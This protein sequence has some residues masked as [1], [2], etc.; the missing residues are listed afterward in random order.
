M[1]ATK[2]PHIIPQSYP[3]L[4]IAEGKNLDRQTLVNISNNH[5]DLDNS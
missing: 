2:H 4:V 1:E 5:F 3:W